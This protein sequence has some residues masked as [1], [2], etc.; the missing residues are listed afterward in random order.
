MPSD[1]SLYWYDLETFGINHKYQR[2]AQFAGVRTNLD[3]EIIDQPLV[4]YCKP[5][6]DFLP[7]PRSCLITGITPQIA[8]EKGVPEPVFIDKILEQFIKPKTCVVGYNNLR[9]DD[10]FMRYAFYRNLHDPYER[11]WRNGNSRWDI[12]DLVRAT[13]S[14]RPEGIQW[15]DKDEG[16]PSFRLEDLTRANGLE[17]E[18][19]HDALSDVHATIAMAK[20]VKQQQPR[21]YDF[22]FTNRDKQSVA[23]L[24][25]LNERPLLVHISGMYKSVRGCMAVIMPLL[26]HPINKNGVIV[27]DLSYDCEA[28]LSL[29]PEEIKHRIY[30]AQDDLPAGVARIP[31]KTIHYNKCPIIAP[32]NTLSDDICVRYD[33]NLKR[34]AQRREFLLSNPSIAE[35]LRAVFFDRP[36]F[37]NQDVDESLYGGFFSNSDKVKLETIRT[38]SYSDTV[39]YDMPFDDKRIPELIFRYRARNYPGTLSPQQKDDWNRF[40][41]DRLH[42]REGE[43]PFTVDSFNLIIQELKE[44]QNSDNTDLEILNSLDS[45]LKTQLLV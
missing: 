20:L 32:I 45:Y 39:V 44:D 34:C 15:P 3:L 30:T 22:V 5:S 43:V 8:Q 27:I 4:L 18:H 14:L 26:K 21:L 35:K 9:F 38:A 6:L 25:R 41:I 37:P 24:M 11:E 1:P 36:E 42:G 33:I 16:I 28:L 2:I 31:I 13:R 12:V 17:H 19:A 10:E 7:D 40:R 29:S 23:K